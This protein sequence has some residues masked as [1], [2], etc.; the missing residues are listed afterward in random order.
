M[1]LP[2]NWHEHNG[3]RPRLPGFEKLFRLLFLSGSY[4]QIDQ[5][6]QL[7]LVRQPAMAGAESLDEMGTRPRFVHGTHV[8]PRHRLQVLRVA[9]PTL[10]PRDHAGPQKALGRC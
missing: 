6:V 4:A 5:A 8:L 1:D 7:R 2:H 10:T 3:P 9:L